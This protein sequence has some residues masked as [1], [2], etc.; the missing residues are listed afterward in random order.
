MWNEAGLHSR[1][2]H[3]LIR[4]YAEETNRFHDNDA[5]D[6]TSQAVHRVVAFN[7]CI[8]E[9]LQR[10]RISSERFHPWSHREEDRRTDQ[11]EE[12]KKQ[13]RRDDLADTRNKLGRSDS[14]PP[15]QKEENENEDIQ[16]DCFLCIRQEWSRRN[17]KRN[18][19][20]T[21]NREERSDRQVQKRAEQHTVHRMDTRSQLLKT[22]ARI[23]NRKHSRKRKADTR[24]QEADRSPGR[25]PASILAQEYRE[26]Q[27]PCAEK[28]REKHEPDRDKLSGRFL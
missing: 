1:T 8:R 12:E 19:S 22:C 18:R 9:S 23:T 28:Q 24:N 25:I 20:R 17:F 15:G 26:N 11:N 16:P 6:K 2:S 21:G 3:F 10:S 5:E 13:H 7:Q 27:I 4:L 14:Q